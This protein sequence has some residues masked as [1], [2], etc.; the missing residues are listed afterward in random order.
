V[1]KLDFERLLKPYNP[2]W[3]IE[4]RD[5]WHFELPKFNRPIV[6]EIIDDLDFIPQIISITGPRRVG[7]TTALYQSIL[8][9]IAEKSINPDYITYFSFDDPEV[10]SSEETQRIVFEELIKFCTNKLK[11]ENIF[12][13]FLDE[14]QRLPKWELY[15][16][17]YYDLK[18]PIRFIISGSASS[19]IFRS[20]QETLLGRIKDRHLLPFSFK[21]YCLFKLHMQSG[22]SEIISNYSNIRQFLF[23]NDIEGLV[24]ILNKAASDLKPYLSNIDRA[25]ISYLREGGFPEVW[26]IKDPVRKIEYLMEQQIRKV[27][28]E[29]LMSLVKYKKPENILRFLVYLLGHP[30]IEIN[31]TKTANDIGVTKTLIEENLPRLIITDLILR[32]KKFAHQPLRVRQGNIKCYPVD[33][34]LRNAVFK[35]WDDPSADPV[36]MGLYAENMVAVELSKWSEAIEVSYFRKRDKEVDFIV[37]YGGNNYL[38]FEVKHR[39]IIKTPNGLIYFMKKY[40]LNIGVVVTK[41][42]NI[43]YKN[44]VFYL[45]LL[46]FLLFA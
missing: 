44:D 25:V 24:K 33:L 26:E 36:A 5:S 13:L 41:E 19:P 46:Y 1:N 45:P 23:K 43:D 20:S 9:L 14:I 21:E 11:D 37:A 35:T 17:K 2:W 10:F 16:K 27:L 28:F 31:I 3:E 42:R 22:F 12:Y 7:K 18:S 29:D 8:K 30:G 6:S 39:N 34:A 4:K 40:N 15:L 32:I 38:P